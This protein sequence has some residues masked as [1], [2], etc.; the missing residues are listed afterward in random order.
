MATKTAA[1][2]MMENRRQQLRMNSMKVD[3]STRKPAQAGQRPA[4]QVQSPAPQPQR[5]SSERFMVGRP[6]PGAESE[7]PVKKVEVINRAT[8]QVTLADGTVTILPK[9]EY[10]KKFNSAIQAESKTNAMKSIRKGPDGKF[11]ATI[12]GK[13]KGIVKTYTTKPR[14]EAA[15]TKRYKEKK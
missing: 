2:V 8:R 1:Q 7:A 12:G 10:V 9:E 11:H 14:A 4:P 15:I 3:T 13:A 5:S 6:L